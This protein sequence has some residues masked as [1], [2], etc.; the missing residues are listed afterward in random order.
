MLNELYL[1]WR[2]E[3]SQ[4][5]DQLYMLSGMGCLSYGQGFLIRAVTTAVLKASGAHLS[6]SEQFTKKVLKKIHLCELGIK[7]ILQVV[8]VLKM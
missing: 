3:L 2:E 4:L 5:S 1:L 6:M 8:K 7:Q